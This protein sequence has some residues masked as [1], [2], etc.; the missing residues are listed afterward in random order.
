MS[1]EHNIEL[2]AWLEKTEP[3]LAR[4]LAALTD[5]ARVTVRAARCGLPTA[6]VEG[7]S[8]HSEYDPRRE[9]EG[10]AS[11]GLE[12]TAA[13]ETLLV[14][15][16]GLGYLPEALR[17]QFSGAI[18]VVEPDAA[19]LKAALE[20]RDLSFLKDMKLLCGLTPEAVVDNIQELCSGQW[21]QIKLI[22]HPPSQKLQPDY[23]REIKR[24]INSRRNQNLG[25]L[26]ILVV[27]PIYGGSLPVAGYCVNAFRRLG[28]RVEVLDNSIYDQ[29]RLQ[30]DAITYNL[31]HRKTLSGLFTTLMAESITARAL[32]RAVDL[33]FLV[34][35]SPMTP[36]VAREL[37]QRRIPV[38]FWFVE[39]WRV[40]PYWKQV[41]PLYDYLF[42][43][44]KGEFF[45]RLHS[46][47]VKRVHYLPMAADPEIHRPLD[48]S[49]A[50]LREFG[51]D[52]SH[53]GAG[54]HNRRQVFAELTDL[55]FR[56]W[57]TGWEDAAPLAAALQRGG[58]RLSTE[59]TVKVFNAAKINL[60]LHSS[61]FHEGVNPDGDYVNPRTF[62][63]AAAGA[64]QLTDHRQLLSE[65]FEPGSEIV[66]FR[67]ERELRGLIEHYLQ[68]PEERL[69]IATR[70]RLRALESHTYEQRMAEALHFIFSYESMPAGRRHP[71]H[72]DNLLAAAEGDDELLKLLERFRDG[73]VITLDEI[74]ED[75]QRRA[76]ALTRVETVFLLMYEF[77]RWAREKGAV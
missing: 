66:V 68:H 32:E 25:R 5:D 45:D 19:V 8:L 61:P 41:A 54:Y 7:V 12:G 48:L 28:H 37:K 52:V 26:G 14:F 34:A 56:L 77:R 27:T 9:A 60:N 20:S 46:I 55:N 74:I 39:D 75:I 18:I 72:I 29:A 69:T 3:E 53:V 63:L 40:M 47:G 22:S 49:P 64:F 11:K 16:L 62:E 65:L 6:A 31:Q 1:S 59:D 17:H 42:T 23:Y 13:D 24:L 30:L 76:G 50:E 35:Q 33:V 51:S 4:T 21:R 15:G 58:R 2:R 57:G 67:H 38:A 73:G 71:D 10:Q 43:V 36:E 70:A 44:Q